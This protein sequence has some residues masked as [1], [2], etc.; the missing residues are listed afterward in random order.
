MNKKRNSGIS[1]HSLGNVSNM[2]MSFSHSGK[3]ETERSPK[4]TPPSTNFLDGHESEQ[5]NIS[6]VLVFLSLSSSFI[7][8]LSLK[9]YVYLLRFMAN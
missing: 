4:L 7:P 6:N 3:S 8:L 9:L 5:V 1:F 2:K